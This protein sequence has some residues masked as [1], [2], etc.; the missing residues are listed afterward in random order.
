[1]SKIITTDRYTVVHTQ[2]T[3]TLDDV[4]FQ[5]IT[6]SKP[7]RELNLANAEFA[8]EEAEI[9]AERNL[10]VVGFDQS[11]LSC[12]EVLY[13]DREVTEKLKGN[14]LITESRVCL[15]AWA[16]DNCLVALA[17]DGGR[18]VAILHASVITFN[19]D[20]IDLAI[21]EMH[22]RRVKDIVAYVGV[23][24]GKCCCEYRKE[25]IEQYSIFSDWPEFIIETDIPDKVKLDLSGAVCKSLQKNGAEVV[26][27]FPKCECSACAKEGKRYMFPSFG[28]EKYN[29]GQYGLFI[30]KNKIA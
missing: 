21:E 1:M 10:A 12:R 3:G 11:D 27:L 29:N 18:V 30:C 6:V 17:G 26:K 24:I 14:I 2:G 25:V 7:K 13:P 22:E 28:R 5:D 15:M 20:I 19:N 9:R 8:C 23:C 4:G 16:S